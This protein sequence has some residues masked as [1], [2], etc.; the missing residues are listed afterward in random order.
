MHTVCALQTRTH[1]QKS[2]TDKAGWVSDKPLKVRR[3]GAG[4]IQLR[5]LARSRH[6]DA[7]PRLHNPPSEKKKKTAEIWKWLVS[8]GMSW[9]EGYLDGVPNFITLF[10]GHMMVRVQFA[11]M[12]M[13]LDGGPSLE[14][15]CLAW[16]ERLLPF[17]AAI[18]ITHHPSSL[19]HSCNSYIHTTSIYHPQ[20][21]FTTHLD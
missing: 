1:N 15:C 12:T 18:S 7:I 10:Y 21:A 20:K 2:L 19:I 6:P 14:S 13:T 3:Q 9:Y 11:T 8:N 16:D 17:L 5:S 4:N